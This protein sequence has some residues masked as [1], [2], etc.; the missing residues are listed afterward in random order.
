MFKE[1]E[2]MDFKIG[3]KKID[4][5]VGLVFGTGMALVLINWILGIIF[6]I[7]FFV[8]TIERMN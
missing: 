1:S 4:L 7:I 8:D 3:T 6:G 2:L 5:A